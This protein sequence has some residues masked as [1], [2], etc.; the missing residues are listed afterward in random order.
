[1]RVDCVDI[2]D[3]STKLVHVSTV[4]SW[5]GK[6]MQFPSA[7]LYIFVYLKNEDF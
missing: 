7:E 6:N 1:M 5:Q 3:S 2:A 4:P